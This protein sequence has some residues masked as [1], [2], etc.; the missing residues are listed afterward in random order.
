M[1]RFPEIAE[2][3]QGV[4]GSVYSGLKKKPASGRPPVPLHVGDTWMEPADG[5]RMQ[6]LTIDDHPGMHRYSP[7]PGYPQLRDRIAEVH[8]ERTGIATERSQVLV[9]GG[10]TAGLAAVVGALVSPGEEVL[11]IAPYWP[12]IAGSVRAFGATPVD[13]PMMTEVE[14][15]EEAVARLEQHRS[16]KTVAVYWNTPHNPT[17]RLLPRD[18]LEAMSKWARKHNLW[19]FS[20]DVYE[21]YVYKGEHVYT[22]SL[23]PDNTISVHSFSKAYGMAGNRCGYLTGPNE[24]IDAVKRIMTNINYSACSASQLAALKALDGA[25]DDWV[26]NAREKYAELGRHAAMALK[27]PE[28]K[29][30]TF[31]FPDVSHAL[32]DRGLDGFLGDLAEAGVLVAPGPSFGPYPEHIRLCFTAAPPAEIRRGVKILASKLQ[33]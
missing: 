26:A 29:G 4:K 20:D 2:S 9:T 6:D 32:D 13:V 15:A 22:R 5:C 23:S 31:L 7:V 19:I 18:W 12:L 11:L 30:S 28:P 1:P 10:A 24:A 21:D 33:N 3:V 27:L 14:A 16:D 8:G 17:G 25:A